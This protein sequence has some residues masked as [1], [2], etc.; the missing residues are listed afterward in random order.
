ML[1]PAHSCSQEQIVGLFS[2]LCN[3]IFSVAAESVYPG[4]RSLFKVGIFAHLLAPTHTKCSDYISSLCHILSFHKHLQTPTNN[5]RKAFLD[6]GS[7]RA[8]QSGD[9]GRVKESLRI[10]AKHLLGNH[11]VPPTVPSICVLV[12]FN[13]CKGN[14]IIIIQLFRRKTSTER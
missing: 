14:S 2:Q 5:S 10:I 8:W 9:R 3:T 1:E 11:Y 13:H 4:L 7:S 12:S 6:P